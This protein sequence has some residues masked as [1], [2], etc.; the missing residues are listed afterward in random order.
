MKVNLE[1]DC[2]PWLN[3]DGTVSVGIWF[4]NHCEPSLEESFSLKEMVDN[5]LE[6]LC[7]KNEIQECHFDDVEELLTS[8][9]DLCEYAKTRAKN[10]GYEWNGE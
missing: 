7:V 2:S 5:T 9:N 10:L 6:S 4:G 3:E 8:L 1:I